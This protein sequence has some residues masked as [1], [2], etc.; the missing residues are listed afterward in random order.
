K[1]A[2]ALL[3]SQSARPK[4]S[5]APPLAR[6]RDDAFAADVV[7]PSASPGTADK[8]KMKDSTSAKKVAATIEGDTEASASGRGKPA[9]KKDAAKKTTSK[10]TAK[11]ATLLRLAR[12]LERSG[13][14]EQALANYRQVVKDFPD[15]QSAKTAADRIKALEKD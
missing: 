1:K 15:S 5:Q 4:S 6:G 8:A 14:T 3:A 10:G 12:T 9:S 13:K 2:A 7:E 11:A